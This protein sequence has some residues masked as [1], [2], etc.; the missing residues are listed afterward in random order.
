[1]VLALE[2]DAGD[3][4]TAAAT[5]SHGPGSCRCGGCRDKENDQDQNDPCDKTKGRLFHKSVP[6]TLS[7]ERS[8]PEHGRPSVGWAVPPPSGNCEQPGAGC[9][10][11]LR[12]T[13]PPTASASQHGRP[14][15]GWAVPPPS[16][17]C[18]QPGA[19]CKPSLRQ[20]GPPTASASQHGRPSVGWAVPPSSGSDA[21]SQHLPYEYEAALQM[22]QRVGSWSLVAA[23]RLPVRAQCTTFPGWDESIATELTNGRQR[24]ILPASEDVL[25][26]GQVIRAQ[27]TRTAARR[28]PA[29]CSRNIS[30]LTFVSWAEEYDMSLAGVLRTDV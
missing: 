8:A 27:R 6:E 20:T 2:R 3:D 4:A 7:A 5:G 28:R 23:T 26:L 16:G 22:G 19:G 21:G 30:D 29:G 14:S 11:S 9:K 24:C 1:M 17:N 15:V 12:Q 18:E 13:G 10:P 25:Q